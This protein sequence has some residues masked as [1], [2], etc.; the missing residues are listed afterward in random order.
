MSAGQHSSDVVFRAFLS[1]RYKSPEVNEYFFK[2]FDAAA[3]NPQFSVDRGT[4]ATSVTRLE[5]LIRSTD[6]FI[7]IYPFPEDAEVTPERLRHES[8]YFRLE[9]GLAERAAKPA[10]I[11]IDF[12]FGAAIVP[13]PS[14]V[15]IR[16]RREEIARHTQS[17][18]SAEFSNRVGDFCRRVAAWR[19]YDASLTPEEEKIKVGILL[20]PQDPSG[21]G[22][23]KRHIELI[24]AEIKKSKSSRD[25]EILRWPP[26]LG[27]QFSRSIE[28]LDWIVVD[29]GTTSALFGIV[30]YLHGRFIPMM[31]LLQVSPAIA[32]AEPSPLVDA[33]YS[34][35]EVG[36]P[37]DIVRWSDEATLQAEIE[38][39]IKIFD[40]PQTRIATREEA[41]RYFR[42]AA[43]RNEAIFVSYSG[44]DA[45]TAAELITA[46]KGRFQQVFDYRGEDKPIQAGS[47]WIAEIFEQLA[48]SPIGVP[49]FSRS[50]FRSRHCL[51]EGREMLARRN[52][53]GMKVV[54]IKLR[55]EEI[56]VPAEFGEMQYL[57][58][59]EH[60]NASA[61]VN[62]IIQS[63]DG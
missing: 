2:I 5:R 31:R 9:L 61:L 14:I 29:I 26:L 50:Y 60:Q 19:A 24:E 4:I 30:G 3:A 59:W 49:L 62:S 6:A 20:P 7:G 56:K 13:P 15:Q 63:I 36:Y 23:T 48:A 41:S 27:S 12:Q 42:S 21:N 58:L 25:V 22:Y 10:L 46:L 18:R 38:Q 28:E 16:F 44:R 40:A 17:P 37:K 33:L 8:R 57:R 39:R 47:S 52:D 53:G 34:A 35:Y 55:R 51:H 11:F 54:P 1:H 32:T 43:L 45:N